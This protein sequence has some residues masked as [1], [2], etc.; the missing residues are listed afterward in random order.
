MNKL[1]KKYDKL[2]G[3]CYTQFITGKQLFDCWNQTF[4][5]LVQAIETERENNGK[6][7]EY[8][9]EIGEELDYEVDVDGWLEDYLDDLEVRGQQER[10]IEVC[11]KII[12]L[13]RWETGEQTDFRFRISTAL[14]ALNRKEEALQLCEDWYRDEK[15]NIYAAVALTYAKIGMKD[16]EGAEKIIT[17]Y[18]T[19]DTRCDEENE[20]MFVAAE[21]LYKLNKNKKAA[22][23]I[24]EELERYENEVE[25]FLMGID[26]D[27]EFDEEDL[28]FN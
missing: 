8:Y 1:W 6:F 18:I 26:N 15:E 20:T 9:Y 12:S 3:E 13:F 25:E 2:T 11:N 14:S 27:F 22:K 7:A 28:P 4:D 19:E 16:F 21:T 5:T 23:R 17:K 10:V 24:E